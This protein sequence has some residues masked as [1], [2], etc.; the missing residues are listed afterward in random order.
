[1]CAN[2]GWHILKTANR[3]WHILKTA[4]RGWHILKTA[5]RGW[6]ILKTADRGWH[7]LK[8]AHAQQDHSPHSMFCNCAPLQRSKNTAVVP[9][10]NAAISYSN[11]LSTALGHLRTVKHCRKENAHF[12]SL[13]IHKLFFKSVHK[14]NP[15][16][17][18][19]Q[20]MHTQTSNT[21]L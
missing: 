9:R 5:E 16:T 2:R 18:I 7:I 13:F 6:H 15:Y 14:T 12:K 8:T 4:D 19:K 3:G 1:M 20:N 10:H 17:N 21:D 11:I